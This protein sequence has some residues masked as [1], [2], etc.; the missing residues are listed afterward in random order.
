MGDLYFL[1]Y[2][3]DGSGGFSSVIFKQIGKDAL[4]PDLVLHLNRCNTSLYRN[5]DL[6]NILKLGTNRFI[7]N[8]R[9]LYFINL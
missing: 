2:I 8:H 7:I 5:T 3:S 4:Y 6:V 1:L 9:K